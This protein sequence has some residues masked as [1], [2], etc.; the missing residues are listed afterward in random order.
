MTGAGDAGT[1][2][3]GEALVAAGP[4]GVLPVLG[5]QPRE[6][7]VGGWAV[8]GLFLL[9]AFTGPTPAILIGSP[10]LSRF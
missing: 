3:A 4:V 2:V 7:P 9:A 8:V 5:P 10:F 1:G 6:G